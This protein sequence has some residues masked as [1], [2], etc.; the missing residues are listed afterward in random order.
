VSRE[1]NSLCNA[2]L[3]LPSRLC[4]GQHEVPRETIEKGIELAQKA[5]AIDDSIPSAHAL[6]SYFYM[7]KREYNKAIA[8]GNGLWLSTGW[9]ECPYDLCP[10][11]TL[12]RQG[13]G[14]H[15]VS[16]KSNPTQPFRSK[17][18]LLYFRLC[19]HGDGRFQES[20]SAFKKAIQRAPDNILPHIGLA[21]TY[22][23]MGREKEAGA[24]A[25]EV[26]R[27]NPK[28]SVDNY[29]KQFLLKI[30]QKWIKSL[31]PCT[32]GAEIRD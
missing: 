25:A 15:S 18:L 19:P 13:R 7:F 31:T 27:I 4:P 5:L 23:M 9:D 17:H 30:N 6:L 1:S 16:P 26:L 28:F 24:E 12:C 22:S 8:E 29:A 21:A 32:S 2:R 3:G 11:S 20:I 14:S 10:Q